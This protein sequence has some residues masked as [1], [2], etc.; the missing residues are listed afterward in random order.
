VANTAY[1]T[2]SHLA[3]DATTLLPPERFHFEVLDIDN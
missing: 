1:Q 2:W 3:P